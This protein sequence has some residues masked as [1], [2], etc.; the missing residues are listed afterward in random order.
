MNF[1]LLS[2]MLIVNGQNLQQA[3]GI[4]VVGGWS[5]PYGALLSC[6]AWHRPSSSRNSTGLLPFLL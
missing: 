2:D 6:S 1:M 3:L 5:L 4:F